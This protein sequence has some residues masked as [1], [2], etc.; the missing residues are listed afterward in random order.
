MR[1]ASA[2]LSAMPIYRKPS[3]IRPDVCNSAECFKNILNDRRIGLAQLIEAEQTLLKI[4]SRR[5]RAGAAD[6]VFAIEDHA[7]PVA[8]SRHVGRDELIPDESFRYP[9]VVLSVLTADVLLADLNAIGEISQR[10]HYRV[11][12]GWGHTPFE[13][14]FIESHEHGIERRFLRIGC[15]PWINGT[16]KA[17]TRWIMGFD[18]RADCGKDSF[19][20]VF[21]PIPAERIEPIVDLPVL[22]TF[23]RIESVKELS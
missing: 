2:A 20:F 8:E 19:N 12:L 6:R 17:E 23:S 11:V 5:L 14:Q 10:G 4:V 16:A 3:D 9:N 22:V 18:N 21:E 13:D 1:S 15:G 7:G